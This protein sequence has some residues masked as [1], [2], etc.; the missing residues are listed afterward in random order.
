MPVRRRR[1]RRERQRG[2]AA[3]FA[4]MQGKLEAL[5]AR[6]LEPTLVEEDAELR[7]RPSPRRAPTLRDCGPR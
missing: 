1:S 5:Q 7:T 6:M 4:N 3:N 2:P